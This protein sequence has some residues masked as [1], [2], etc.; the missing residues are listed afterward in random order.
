MSPL[1]HYSTCLLAL[2]FFCAQ[3]YSVY[4]NP[5]RLSAGFTRGVNY[6]H[7]HRRWHGYGSKVSS[8]QL[9][10]LKNIGIDWIALTPF[11]YQHIAM[12][13]HI[14]TAQGRVDATL[15]DDDL[16]A[17]ITSSHK[18]HMKVLLKPHIWSHDFWQAKQWHGTVRQLLQAAHSRWWYTYRSLILH[19]ATLAQ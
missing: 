3:G 9:V 4:A 8:Q 6:A 14:I 2:V 7:I 17:Q 11:G 12:A 10:R 19:Y 1:I 5:P 13:D 15:T 18:L 16:I